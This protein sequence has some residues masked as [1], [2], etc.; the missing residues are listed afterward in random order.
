MTTLV[1]ADTIPHYA[2]VM[3]DK[4]PPPPLPL[5]PS[6]SEPLT[7]APTPLLHNSAAHFPS[8]SQHPALSQSESCTET[9][10]QP[11]SLNI[12]TSNVSSSIN[13]TFPSTFNHDDSTTSPSSAISSQ[14]ESQATGSTDLLDRK[15]LHVLE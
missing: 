15:P 7:S 5:P 4:G 3:E 10:A 13:N 12:T 2:S 8:S 9:A 6:P 11:K 14:A 1:E